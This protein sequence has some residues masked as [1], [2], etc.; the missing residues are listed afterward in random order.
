MQGQHAQL[1]DHLLAWLLTHTHSFLT[2][3]VDIG[4]ATD[5]VA[6]AMKA[7]WHLTTHT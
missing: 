1:S 5:A 2:T 3:T 4:D 6:Q 7:V